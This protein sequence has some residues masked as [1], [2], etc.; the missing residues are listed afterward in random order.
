MLDRKTLMVDSQ[1]LQNRRIKIVDMNWILD[2]VVAEI[3]R[4][5]VVESCFESASSHASGKAA[6]V[7]ISPVVIQSSKCLD[8]KSFVRIP[9]RISRRYRRAGLAV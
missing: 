4:S 1:T 3:V 6:S 8:Y 2:D 5:T 7:V 9:R